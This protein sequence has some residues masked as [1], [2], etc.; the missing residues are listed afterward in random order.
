MQTDSSGLEQ[1]I[2]D[3]A[4][5]IDKTGYE[6]DFGVTQLRRVVTGTVQRNSGTP[7]IGRD[8]HMKR[9]PDQTLVVERG[10]QPLPECAAA[11]EDV[12]QRTAMEYRQMRTKSE[13][14]I[15]VT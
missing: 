8:A 2:G 3:R 1:A 15:P 12:F 14:D 11:Q 4:H 7:L 5:R 13:T 9:I 10:L 6:T